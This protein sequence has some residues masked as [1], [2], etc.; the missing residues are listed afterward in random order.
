MIDKDNTQI[1]FNNYVKYLLKTIPC[2]NLIISKKELS[3]NIDANKIIP[4]F[5]FLKY[6]T[7][8]QYKLISDICAVDYP[9]K[10]NRFTIVYN[11]L[12]IRFNSR[13][14][15][16]VMINEL[17]SINSITSIYKAASWWEREVWDLFGIFF[18]NHPDLRR[19]LT[20]YG[21]EGH[22]LRKDFPLSGYLEVYYNELKKM[23][24]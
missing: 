20:D 11:L 18:N 10:I 15:I 23:N 2:K 6:H 5:F 21:F 22:P 3:L 16:K 13:L 9:N 14:R 8:C 7:N 12:S 24:Y 19:I 1:L 4:I 17:Q